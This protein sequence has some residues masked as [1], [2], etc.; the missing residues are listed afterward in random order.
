MSP[1]SSNQWIDKRSILQ[2]RLL[3]CFL[4][5]TISY[6]ISEHMYLSPPLPDRAIFHR[7]DVPS[8]IAPVFF[9]C[10]HKYFSIINN[11]AKQINFKNLSLCTWREILRHR[12]VSHGC[13]HLFSICSTNQPFHQQCICII[14]LHTPTLTQCTD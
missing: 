9:I 1:S 3:L 11:T 5:L 4:S 14:C 2:K 6:S 10:D 12:F 8:F 7:M 13:T